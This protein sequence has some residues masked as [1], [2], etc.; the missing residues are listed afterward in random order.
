MKYAVLKIGGKQY[1][2]SEGDQLLVEKIDKNE[3]EPVD[4]K[5][6][7]L[8]V[9]DSKVDV[10]T[11]FLNATVKGKILTQEK[12]QKVQVFRYK[13]KT[14]YHKKTGHRQKLTKVLIEKISKGSK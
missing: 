8:L 11:P 2:A 12:A 1:K 9:D 3:N 13:S 7:L 10:G 6:V 4:F 5:E 14:G